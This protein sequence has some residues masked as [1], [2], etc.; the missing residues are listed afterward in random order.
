[1]SAVT[2]LEL[3]AEAKN[4]KKQIEVSKQLKHISF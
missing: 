4:K 1:M 3:M 2:A